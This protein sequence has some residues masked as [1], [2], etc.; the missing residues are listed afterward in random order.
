MGVK[1]EEYFAKLPKLYKLLTQLFDNYC[2]TCFR[3]GFR[4]D[5][6]KKFKLWLFQII[7]YNVKF[8]GFLKV[9]QFQ[10][11][12]NPYCI[13]INMHLISNGFK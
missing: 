13:S 12:V 8:H 3:M 9:S 5:I 6:L 7:Q 10:F 4:C 1:L 11:S 2:I